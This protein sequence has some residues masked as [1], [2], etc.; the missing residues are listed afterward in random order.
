MAVNSQQ[1]WFRHGTFSAREN[2]VNLSS[3]E[4]QIVNLTSLVQQLTTANM[5]QVKH[6]GICTSTGYP[7]DMCPTFRENLS[8]Y[9]DSVEGFLHPPQRNYDPYLNIYNPWW[10]DYPNFSYGKLLELLFNLYIIRLVVLNVQGLDTI[11][12]KKKQ[13]PIMEGL[14]MI[15]NLPADIVLEILLK[16]PVKYLLRFNLVCKSWYALIDSNEFKTMYL[17]R[18]LEATITKVSSSIAAAT[19]YQNPNRFV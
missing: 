9:V 18:N 11:P 3:V 6:C 1:F 14:S 12:Q 17:D 7:T 15:N 5:Q 4:Y 19:K 16:L 13:K 2:G 8:K 10:S